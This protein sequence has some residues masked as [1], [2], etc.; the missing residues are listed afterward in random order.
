MTLTELESS[1]EPS[2]IVNDVMNA[3]LLLLDE[4]DG[5]AMVNNKSVKLCRAKVCGGKLWTTTGP[6]NSGPIL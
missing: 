1:T 5:N 4:H 3:A 6:V 2:T